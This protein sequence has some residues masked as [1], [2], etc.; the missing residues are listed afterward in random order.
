MMIL[1]IEYEPLTEVKQML[2]S[3]NNRKE[4]N[5]RGVIPQ[6]IPLILLHLSGNKIPG[7]VRH[8]ELVN[9]DLKTILGR[10]QDNTLS[11]L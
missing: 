3:C 2:F 4:R 5:M 1:T 7:N 10:A 6:D 9:K 8:P 11:T